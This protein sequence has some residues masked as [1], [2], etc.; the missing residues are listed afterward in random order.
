ML[1][2]DKVVVVAGAAGLLG[3]EIAH[4]VAAHGGCPI[5]ADTAEDAADA[6]SE[7]IGKEFPA[8]RPMAVR[9]DVTSKASFE[10]LFG[11]VVARFGRLDGFVNSAY[12]RNR[13]YGSHFFDVTYEDFCENTNLHLG[14]YFLAMQQLAAHF[15]KSGGGSIVSLASV[16]GFTAPRFDI[17]R[18]T[19][20]TTP[21]EYAA[22]K[23]GVI[24]LTRFVAKHMKDTMVRV[25]CVSPGGIADGQPENFLNAYAAYCRSK[26][27][28]AERDVTGAVVFLL[29]D[30]S[31]FMTGQN[32]VVDD[33]FS[34]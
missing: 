23:A 19:S 22:I 5:I 4:T 17:Y 15:M 2:K 16:Y 10:N 7:A 34:L 11:V 20:M 21:V 25:N 1:L 33:G 32:L 6:V 13:N 24:Q 30:L 27:M 18:N 29:S 9:L 8:S 26:G 31:A 12:P 14:G 3:R 28:L